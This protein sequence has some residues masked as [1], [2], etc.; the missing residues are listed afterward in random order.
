M[1]ARLSAPSGGYIVTY[2]NF[3][4]RVYVTLITKTLTRMKRLFLLIALLA[5]GFTSGFSRQEENLIKITRME[6]DLWPDYD[7]SQMLVI[8]RVQISNDTQL[9]VRINLRIPGTAAPYKVAMRDLDGL[10]YNLAYS[11]E[12]EGTWREI[13]LSTSSNELYIEY[14]DPSIVTNEEERSY[15]FSWI[16]DYPIDKLIVKAQQPRN[17]QEFNASPSMGV[18]ELNIVDKLVYYTRDFGPLPTGITFNSH[19]SYTRT[20]SELSASNLPVVAATPL[21]VNAGFNRSVSKVIN[22][23][24]DNRGLAISGLLILISIVLMLVVSILS[25]TWSNPFQNNSMGLPGTKNSDDELSVHIQYCPHCGKR[26][27]AGDR[28]CRGCGNII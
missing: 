27:N 8:Y 3:F 2:T 19:I 23:L 15:S 18:G 5:L 26:T 7:R 24:L 6:I 16:S 21:A 9:P 17:S 12:P 22:Q 10:L 25:G 20:S 28:Y 1:V 14:Y 13:V 11:V 4:H